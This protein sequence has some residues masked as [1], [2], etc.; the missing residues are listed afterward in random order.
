MKHKYPIGTWVRFYQNGSLVIGVVQYIL[1]REHWD[2][3]PRYFTD[4]GPLDENE[5]LEAR[6]P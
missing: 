2:T 5:I 3:S 4:R 1:K 6:L